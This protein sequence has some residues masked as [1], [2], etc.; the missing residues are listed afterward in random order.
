MPLM[1]DIDLA[2]FDIAGTTIRDSDY[3][4][5][6]LQEA[7]TSAGIEVPLPQIN[8]T[9]GLPKPIAIERLLEEAGAEGDV[10]SIHTD[11]VQRM[12]RFYLESD[13][14]APYE[15][16][17]EA[18]ATLRES[19]IRIALDTGFSSD[20]TSIILSRVGWDSGVIDAFVSSD[21]VERGRPYPDMIHHLMK[22][23]G[24]SDVKRVA[25]I[26]DA[27]ADMNEGTNTGCAM[28][29]GVLCGTHTEAQ[30]S[31]YPHTHLIESVRDFPKLVLG[32]Q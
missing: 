4:N 25:K 3:V 9:M 26:G 13:D 15:G 11:F 20:I 14:V 31:E 29:V 28:V 21:E 19:G 6:C 8:A 17:E 18:F 5:L 30:L 27:P 16:V 2:V 23:L 1:P 22:E 24:V 7:F 10:D 12:K 32:D